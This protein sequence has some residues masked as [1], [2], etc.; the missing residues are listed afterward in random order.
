[1]TRS[2]SGS[3]DL[4]AG[5]R[6]AAAGS[7]ALHLDADTGVIPADDLPVRS[8]LMLRGETEDGLERDVSIKA[9]VVTKDE[10]V[11]VIVEMLGTQSMVGAEAPAFE[12][13]ED[14]MNP[15]ERDVSSHIADDTGVVAIAF[16]AWIGRVAVG[17]QGRTGSDVRLDEGVNV[18]GL[19]ARDGGEADAARQGVEVS[20]AVSLGFVRLPGRM[21]D[22][23]HRADDEHLAGLERT[24]RVFIRPKWHFGLVDL[25]DALQRI[26]VRINHRAPQFLFQQPSR[27]VGANPQ[28]AHQ[29]SRRHAIGMR[30]HEV[31]RPEPGGQRQLGPVHH[32]A[33]RHRGLGPA[34][35]TRVGIGPTR[36]QSRI[37]AAAFRTDESVRPPPIPEQMDAALLVW[38]PCLKL[39]EGHLLRHGLERNRGQAPD[40]RPKWVIGISHG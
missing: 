23:L 29:L 27:F 34:L 17:D 18:D 38:E 7:L 36:H 32:R 31:G 8:G 26:A 5:C 22:H 40:S 16:E 28:L 20:S 1:V 11:E 10:L 25:D 35:P 15:F 6:F 14:S 4:N 30:H 39:L 9:S 21:V 13:S 33:G 12:Q 37:S 3:V 24:R 19:V 2:G